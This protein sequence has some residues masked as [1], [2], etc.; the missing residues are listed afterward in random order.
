MEC[1]I[2]GQASTTLKTVN[3]GTAF[4]SPGGG[5]PSFELVA[6]NGLVYLVRAVSNAALNDFGSKSGF[7]VDTF[8]PTASGNLKLAQAARYQ[9]SKLPFF[10]STYTP[11]TM[12]DTLDTLDYKAVTGETFYAPT[13]FIPIPELDSAN[14]F[15]ANISDFLGEKFWTFVYPEI[16][17]PKGGTGTYNAGYNV[18]ADGKSIL[19]LQK[20]HFV[21]DPL[22]VMVPPNNLTHKYPLQS[23]Q[24]I[25]ALGNDQLREGIVW[26]TRVNKDTERPDSDSPTNIGVQNRSGNHNFDWPNFVFSSSNI[27]VD[28]ANGPSKGMSISKFISISG[29]IYNIE[30]R[31]LLPKSQN[32]STTGSNSAQASDQA[33][34]D[35]ISAVSSV[36]NILIG[37]LFEYDTNDMGL[38]D[39]PTNKGLLF[40]NGYLDSSGYLFSSADH[41]DVNDVLPSQVPRLEQTADILNY[42]ASFYNIDIN[43]PR[44]YWNLTYDTFTS[45]GMSTH[46]M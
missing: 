2:V 39:V 43:L 41:F 15:V 21:Y 18:D 40:L 3:G 9:R 19:K 11:D 37:V 22:A 10:G 30:E 26:R 25:L 31:A 23:K 5:A 17:V 29:T 33:G 13:I 8:V 28:T 42:D 45:L 46:W 1:F 12:V 6:F 20:L 7:L 4:T 27:E 34:Q 36:S 16:V 24:Q 44:Q 14:G 32:I 35:F 38:R